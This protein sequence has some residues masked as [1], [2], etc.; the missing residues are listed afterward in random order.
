MAGLW[1]SG[2]QGGGD[3]S[4]AK[5]TTPIRKESSGRPCKPHLSLAPTSSTHSLLSPPLP[6]IPLPLMSFFQLFP[7]SAPSLFFLPVSLFQSLLPFL[8]PDFVSSPPSLPSPLTSPH[9]VFPFFLSLYPSLSDSLF[10]S[11]PA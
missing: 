9:S 10:L 5:Q 3:G 8:L 7:F 4:E 11:L 2:L 6:S 1:L